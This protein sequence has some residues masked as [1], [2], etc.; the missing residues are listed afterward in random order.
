MQE[1]L[2]KYVHFIG[3]MVNNY[4]RTFGHSPGYEDG[5]NIAIAY[6]K[7]DPPYKRV[8][9]SNAG[10]VIKH[11]CT[12]ICLQFERSNDYTDKQKKR[13]TLE[14]FEL[15][16]NHGFRYSMSSVEI[17]RKKR[18]KNMLEIVNSFLKPL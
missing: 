8:S 9:L 5:V 16:Q 18:E 3:T 15:I 14:I 12:L 7:M 6:E 17:V 4:G 2:R 11:I 13:Q 10:S 1:K